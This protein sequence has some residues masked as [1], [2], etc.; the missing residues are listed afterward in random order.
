MLAARMSELLDA[1]L[2][3]LQPMERHQQILTDQI[4]PFLHNRM[5]R[6]DAVLQQN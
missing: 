4:L 1:L 6:Q 5:Q 3:A 2:E